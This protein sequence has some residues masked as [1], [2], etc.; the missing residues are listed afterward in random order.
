MLT[1]T[2]PSDCGQPTDTDEL[3]QRAYHTAQDVPRG[4]FVLRDSLTSY[5]LAATDRLTGIECPELW[6]YQNI[7]QYWKF[8]WEVA[9]RYSGPNQLPQSRIGMAMNARWDHEKK[10]SRGHDQLHIHVSCIQK[11]VQTALDTL[12]A[13][14]LIATTVQEWKESFY[15]IPAGGHDYNFRVLRLDAEEALSK[16]NLFKLLFYE[17]LKKEYGG[18]KQRRRRTCRTKHWS[19]PRDRR[20]DSTS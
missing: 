6:L 20:E 9:Q 18:T 15:P 16:H 12:D 13:K 1:T 10:P 4:F 19:W 5:L 17:V 11:G 3:W 8:A 2:N 14:N 7:P